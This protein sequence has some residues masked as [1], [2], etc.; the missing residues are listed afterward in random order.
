MPQFFRRARDLAVA[1]D[2]T[3]VGCGHA[4]DGNVHGVTF[5]KDPEIRKKLLTDVFL[6]GMELGGSISGEHG[7]GRAKTSA[8]V[9]QFCVLPGW[10]VVATRRGWP[11]P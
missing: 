10:Q 5:C 3:I 4:G 2:A 8:R 9:S 1:V 11:G 6:L 7:L